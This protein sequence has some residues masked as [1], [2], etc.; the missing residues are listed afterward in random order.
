M[1]RRDVLAALAGS[2]ATPGVAPPG[3]TA[4]ATDAGSKVS[5]RDA[6]T[7]SRTGATGSQES[8]GPVGSVDLRGT[9]E[10][11]V[12]ERRALGYV[13]V[14]DG[15]ATLDLSEPTDPTVL[16]QR[17]DLLA[18]D[19][20][21]PLQQVWDVWPDGDRLLA[22][23]PAQPLP[24]S[25]LHAAVLFDVSDPA[26]P[27]L[28]DVHRTEY[29]IH[30]CFFE[31]G[32][33][34]LTAN[35][36]LGNPLV[37][38][39]AGTDTLEAVGQWA[40]RDHD[41]AWDR[42]SPALRQL[43]DVSVR[44][45]VAYLPYWDAGTYL[46]DVS[47][48]TDPTYLGHVGGRSPGA[49]REQTPLEQS[50]EAT[51]PPGNAHYVQVDESGEVMA[52]GRESWAVSR[53][54]CVTGGASGIDLYDARD[55]TDVTHLASIAPPESYSSTQD[56]PF[57]TAH[58]LDI[59]DGRLYSSWYFGGVKVHDVTDPANPEE[60]AW[61]RRPDEASFWAARRLNPGEH[62]VA[63][64][65]DDAAGYGD[66]IAGRVYVFPDLAGEQ[67][68]PPSLVEPPEGVEPPPGCEDTRDGSDGEGAGDATGAGDETG[69]DGGGDSIPGFGIL[70]AAGGLGIAAARHR[71]RRER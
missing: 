21:G 18:D 65:A 2:A 59:V 69:D 53:G 50:L 60:L 16:A 33:A 5:G 35:G 36:V 3:R 43:H 4:P 6:S 15:I 66:G 49:L 8:F 42:V 14:N 68:D 46:L 39:D 30:N 52:V 19:P 11:A 62:F 28:L 38:V 34:Y 37:V 12:D 58:N 13:A 64:S 29:P 54:S 7:T 44:D 56:G 51:V 57:T 27:S 17:R 25:N 10:L 9:R 40:L 71:R 47:T 48:P 23:G 63:V 24:G 32:V 31:D 22:A 20:D 45:G 55:P 26:D 70:A 67:A 61:W 1:Y 41:D